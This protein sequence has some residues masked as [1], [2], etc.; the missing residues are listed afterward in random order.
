MSDYILV[1]TTTKGKEE[2]ERIANI[3][4]KQKKAACVSIIPN[5]SSIFLW[6]GNIE[7]QDEAQ[8]LIKTKKCL[9]DE[10][11]SLIK[12]NHSYEVPEVIS[13]PIL[14]GYNEYLNWMDETLKNEEEYLTKEH[15]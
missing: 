5:V 13:L 3:L 7:K 15:A 6:K 8:L 14:D 12:S 9:F 2:G 11:V 10:V 1:L 4:I